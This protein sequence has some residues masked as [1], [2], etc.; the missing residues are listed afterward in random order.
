VKGTLIAILLLLV[1]GAAGFLVADTISD[2][3]DA[4][5]GG[6]RGGGGESSDLRLR[7]VEDE[8]EIE[9]LKAEIARLLAELEASKPP[10]EVNPYPDDTPANVERLLEEAYAENNIDW[11]IE[12]IERLL[13]MG[14][15]GYPLLR[16]MLMDI[17]FKAR[18]VPSQ[19]DFR[20]DQLYTAGKVFNKHERQFIGFL[21]FVLSDPNSHPWFQQGAM[22]LGAWYVGS[23]APGAEELQQTL[24]QR[25]LEEQGMDGLGG[26]LPGQITQRMQVFA[27]AMSGDPQMIA[28]LHRELRKTKNKDMQADILGAL[29]YLGDPKALPLIQERLDPNQGD[30]RKELQALAR[31]DTEE[32]H[33][34]A[35]NFLRQIPDSKRFYRHVGRYAR[36]GGGTEAILLMQER[37]KANPSDPE[38]RNVIGSLRRFPTPE[39]KETL[40]LIGNSVTDPRI[41]Q[42]ATEAAEEM[43]ARLRGEVPGFPPR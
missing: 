25:F 33:Q 6:S 10:E 32:S 22:V 37:I 2:P 31:L 16:K 27:M 23:K 3:G 24:M 29:A 11:L 30:Y 40:D 21:N 42:R 41:A 19:S 5:G 14:E 36:A 18:F 39:S 15:D 9:R 20:F 34:I 12:A 43:G 7:I 28:P 17:I 38:I 35:G 26:M 1:G 8:R 13:L 4:R